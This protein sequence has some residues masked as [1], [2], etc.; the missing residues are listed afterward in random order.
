M[1]SKIEENEGGDLMIQN[2]SIAEAPR[3]IIHKYTLENFQCVH[4][5]ARGGREHS[6]HVEP[7]PPCALTF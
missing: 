1:T 6:G 4:K 5:Y 7:R 3:T 2:I